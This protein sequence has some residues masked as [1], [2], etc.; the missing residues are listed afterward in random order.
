MRCCYWLRSIRT[1]HD[2]CFPALQHTHTHT[3]ETVFSRIKVYLNL[4]GWWIIWSLHYAVESLY[5]LTDWCQTALAHPIWNRNGLICCTHLFSCAFCAIGK[6]AIFI[7]WREKKNR[8]WLLFDSR[9]LNFAC[10]K[11]RFVCCNIAVHT[12]ASGRM[13]KWGKRTSNDIW[14]RQICCDKKT[15]A[16][17][18]NM[19]FMSSCSSSW[20]SYEKIVSTWVCLCMLKLSMKCWLCSDD[21]WSLSI[22]WCATQC[23]STDMH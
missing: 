12:S 15:T 2:W 14:S 19:F 17:K 4:C 13:R 11:L 10:D 9:C 23:T 3:R 5:L 20:S 7:K 6:F 8:F 22:A 18:C 1:Q 21:V 16:A